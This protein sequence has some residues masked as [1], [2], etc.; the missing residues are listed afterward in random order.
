[1]RIYIISL[2]FILS[3][4]FNNNLTA[5]NSN[6]NITDIEDQVTKDITLASRKSKLQVDPNLLV[7]AFLEKGRIQ[8]I[9]LKMVYDSVPRKQRIEVLANYLKEKSQIKELKFGF[10]IDEL[11]DF[12]W[13]YLASDIKFTAVQLKSVKASKLVKIETHNSTY[14]FL[15]IEK[16]IQPGGPFLMPI[17]PNINATFESGVQLSMWTGN[18]SLNDL[19]V[20]YAS[21][22]RG[23]EIHIKSIPDNATVFFNKKKWYRTTNTSAVHKPGTWK[24]T[25]TLDGYKEWSQNRNLTPGETWSINASLIKK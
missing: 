9:Q 10:S 16:P 5:Q 22:K 14:D 21:T 20:P 3:L 24:V 4:L 2:V 1:M 12:H 17:M 7:G 6:Y 18:P 23:C 25:I 11:N 19:F 13:A 15:G 8:K